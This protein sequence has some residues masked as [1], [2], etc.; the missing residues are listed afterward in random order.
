MPSHVRGE[1][2]AAP[3]SLG[4]ESTS[5]LQ[6]AQ[7]SG[8]K[9]RWRL[10]VAHPD[11]GPQNPEYPSVCKRSQESSRGMKG[12]EWTV[13][14]GVVCTAVSSGHARSAL[15]TS[16]VPAH[17]SSQDKSEEL[18]QSGLAAQLAETHHAFLTTAWATALCEPAGTHPFLL[19]CVMGR[20]PHVRSSQCCRCRHVKG[21]KSHTFP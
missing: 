21:A 14:A 7:A 9:G 11:T 6:E 18:G 20:M 2:K 15:C 10:Q 5:C 12:N 16:P 4:V 3:R 8:R 13:L 17:V 19:H 1:Q